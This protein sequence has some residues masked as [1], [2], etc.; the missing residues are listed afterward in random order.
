MK[1]EYKLQH[2]GEHVISEALRFHRMMKLNEK[3]WKNAKTK[4]EKDQFEEAS[5]Q[6]RARWAVCMDIIE[7][8]DIEEKYWE[9]YGKQM[10]NGEQ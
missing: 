6:F 5:L 1:A 4:K 7:Y 2:T 10:E 9:A 8:L 3:C